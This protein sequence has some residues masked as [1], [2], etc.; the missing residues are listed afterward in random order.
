MLLKGKVAVVYGAGTIGEAVAKAFGGERARVLVGDRTLTKAEALAEEIEE[1]GG[2]ATGL[3]VD[4]MDEEAVNGSVDAVVGEAGRL[5]VPFNL[6]SVGDVQGTPLAEMGWEGVVRPIENA[7]RS[8]F[9][10]VKAAVPPMVCGGAARGRVDAAA[11]RERAWG[12]RGAVRDA[13]DR[14]PPGHDSRRHG[15]WRGARA[16]PRRSDDDRARGDLEDIGA[17]AA[18]VASDKARTMTAA[19]VNVSAGAG[20]LIDR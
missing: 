9:N 6:I 4:V 7:V 10:A 3:E 13:E 2:V 17:V 15:R 12:G 20:A 1:A 11:I 5:D 16:E 18:F 8:N 14:R 19:T